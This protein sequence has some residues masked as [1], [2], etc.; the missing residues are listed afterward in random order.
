M[1]RLLITGADGFVGRWL[2]REAR[3][4][5]TPVVAAIMPAASPPT[6]W[7]GSGGAAVDVVRADLLDDDAVQ[8][9]A[10]ARPD[11]V[12]HLAAIASGAEA[13]R[14]PDAAVK[15]N[16]AGTTLLAALLAMSSRPRF[17]FVSTGEV[18]GADHA[19]PIDETAPVIPASPYASSKARA[20][21]ALGAIW[22][23][24]GLPVIV[25]RA[26]PHTGPGQS[27]TYVLPALVGRLREAKRTGARTV[28]TGNLSAVRDFL[29][30]RDVVRAYLSLLDHGVPGEC[31]N[32]ASGAGHQLS[33]CFG[34]LAR[35]V[36]VHAVAKPDAALLRSGDIPVLI[37]NASK[38]RA[39]TGWSPQI[40]FEQTLQDLVNAQAD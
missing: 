35:M 31:Y 18:Y 36:G 13:R 16:A 12:V 40:P 6:E 27:A 10:D 5:G 23:R 22:Q 21:A 26:F 38:L 14:D 30:V 20:E 9:L 2:V 1:K 39:A 28:A 4:A 32:V 25:A 37:G 33:E 7:Q 34:L 8:R 19:S 29:D 3:A 11:A 17:L 24:T 15:I